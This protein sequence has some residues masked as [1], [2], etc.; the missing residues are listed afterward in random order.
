MVTM[1][2][3][4]LLLLAL[5]SANLAALE[6][7]EIRKL[8]DIPPTAASLPMRIVGRTVSTA[9]DRGATVQ[10]LQ[11]PGI[12]AEAA[13]E[14]SSLF[15]RLGGGRA[16]FHVIV[17]GKE[18][19]NL[20]STSAAAYELGGLAAGSHTVRLE[21]A[22]ECQGGTVDFI[23]FAASPSGQTAAPAQPPAAR[24]RQIEFIGDSY[25]VGY[26]NTSPKRQCTPDEIWSTTNTSRAF[27]PLVAKHYDADYEINAISGRGIVR[28]YNGGHG[29]T[30]PEAY[31]YSLFNHRDRV[32]DRQW[33][34]DVIVVGLGTNDFSTK[35]NPGEKWK[36]RDELHADF[37][38]TYVH[39]V[40]QLRARHGHAL[41]ILA[42]NDGADGEIAAEVKKVVAKLKDA[43][44][45]RLD[46]VEFDHLELTGCDWHPSLNDDLMMAAAIEKTIDSHAE[47]WGKRAAH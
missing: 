31:P 24:A 16:I 15:I 44:E 45:T 29:E 8:T 43:G 38:K 14:G 9:A 7:S 42:S 2:T 23:G 37:E 10:R 36:T 32:H 21:L 39:F 1:R 6:A 28:N 22:T 35:L 12:Y 3:T 18:P 46:Y 40:S 25:T 34:P 4:H 5:A 47:A 17:D 11:W 41:I 27:G 19:L 30:L 20:T 26:G 13:F 33:G